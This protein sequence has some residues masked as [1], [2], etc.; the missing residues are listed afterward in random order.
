MTQKHSLSVEI[1]TFLG[2]TKL[3]TN[4]CHTLHRKRGEYK[5]I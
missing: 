4:F 5:N 1:Y 3:F 2:V